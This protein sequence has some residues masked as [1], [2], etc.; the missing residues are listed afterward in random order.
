MKTRIVRIGNSR[1]IRLPRVVLE[2]AQLADE[3]ELRAEGGAVSS[4]PQP[5]LGPAGPRRLAGCTRG[6]DQP[7]DPPMTTRFAREEWEWR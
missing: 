4:V 7:L 6:Q 3:V 5:T 2:E 1:D